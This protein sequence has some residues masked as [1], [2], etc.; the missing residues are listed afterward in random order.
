M[1]ETRGVVEWSQVHADVR[2]R[3]LFMWYMWRI[4]DVNVA[5]VQDNAE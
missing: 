1:S 4:E 3:S 5:A 2:D